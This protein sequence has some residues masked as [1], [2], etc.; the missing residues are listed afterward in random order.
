[1][2]PSSSLADRALARAAP[3]DPARDGVIVDALLRV[4]MS[5]AS[6]CAASLA[7]LRTLPAAR[8]GPDARLWALREALAAERRLSARLGIALPDGD[9]VDVD[10]VGAALT[11]AGVPTADAAATRRWT[12]Q[13]VGA[14]NDERPGAFTP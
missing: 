12:E 8:H 3:G 13:V 10:T 6:S 1:M 9:T 7:D 5:P 4:A 2:P 14:L 11:A